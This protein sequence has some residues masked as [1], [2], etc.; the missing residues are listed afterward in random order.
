MALGEVIKV[1]MDCSFVRFWYRRKEFIEEFI[2]KVEGYIE[3]ELRKY[4]EL[5]GVKSSYLEEKDVCV[6]VIVFFL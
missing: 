4:E 5:M 3:N 1:F 6:R 2:R